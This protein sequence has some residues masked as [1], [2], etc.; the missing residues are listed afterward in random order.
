VKADE[1][2]LA[3]VHEPDFADHLATDRRIAMQ[4]S[5]HTHGGQVRVPGIGALRLPS[6]GKRYQAGLYDVGNLKLHVNRGIG[7]IT[8][9]VRFMCPPEIACFDIT[10]AAAV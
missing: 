5:G 2:A 1:R 6:W 8:H 9:H 10:N 4:V 3:L 7:T